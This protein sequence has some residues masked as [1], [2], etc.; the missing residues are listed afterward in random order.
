MTSSSKRV[1][2]LGSRQF[3]NPRPS[4]DKVSVRLANFIM[5]NLI[6]LHKSQLASVSISVSM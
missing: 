2:Q 4:S 6:K 1:I 5:E 3:S